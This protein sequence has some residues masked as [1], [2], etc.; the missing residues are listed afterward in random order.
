MAPVPRLMTSLPVQ[1]ELKMGVM[2]MTIV[3]AKLNVV[4]T[5]VD[6]IAVKLV[7]FTPQV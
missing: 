6:D 2:L 4:T 3:T 1:M 7:E 5:V